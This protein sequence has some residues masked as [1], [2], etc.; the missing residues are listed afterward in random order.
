MYLFK[1]VSGLRD[2]LE[3]FRTKSRKIGFVPTMGALHEGHLSLIRQSLESTQCTVCS[4]FVNPTQF[5]QAEDLEKYPRNPAKDLQMLY[6]VGCHAVFMPPVGEV[7][8]RGIDTSVA[9]DFGQLAEGLEGRFRPGHFQGVAQVVNRL[10]SIVEPQQ[11]F[12]GQKDYQQYLIVRHMVRALELPVEVVMSPTVREANG[13]AMS[14]RNARLSAAQR[15]QAAIIYKSLQDACQWVKQGLSPE[16][17]REKALQQLGIPGFR[18]DYFEVVDGLTMQ[19]LD[20]FDGLGMAV[21][22][23][24]VW[25]GEVR[26]IDNTILQP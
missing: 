25:A 20:N 21:A 24:A 10:L 3:P 26:L 4:I 16:Q 5:N 1:N 15:N 18:P 7:Y 23:T 12:M 2:F 9:I 13:L 14:S 17:V 22:C 6:E 8:P 11:L 19:P